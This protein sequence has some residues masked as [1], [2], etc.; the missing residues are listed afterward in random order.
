VASCPSGSREFWSLAKSVSSNFCNSSFPPLIHPDGSISIDPKSKADSFANLFSENSTLD[1]S[2]A[3]P[4]NYPAATATMTPIKFRSRKIRQILLNLVTNKSNG[5]D[6]IP[7]IVLKRCAPE[8]APTLSK[9]F[10]LSL[11]TGVYPSSWKSAII[12]PIPK[13]GDPSNPSNYRPI[14]VTSI[15]SKVMES[16]INS[17]LLSFL[18]SSSL[19]SD[20]Q[21]GFRQA[22]STGDLLSYVT[23]CWSSALESFGESRVVALDI[24]KAFDRV[25]HK[26]LI[27]KLPMFGIHPK[28]ISWIADFLSCRSIA[29]RIDGA[30]SNQLP[31]NS[32]V[33]QGSVISPTLFLLY[34]NDLLSITSNPIH[35]YADDSN[36]HNSSTYES[37]TASSNSLNT[38][39]ASSAASLNSDLDAIVNWGSTN[40]VSFNHSKTQS[41]L[42]SNKRNLTVPSISMSGSNLTQSNSISMLGIVVT[43]DLSWKSHIVSISKRAARKL[44]FLFRAKKFFTPSQLLI[45]YKSQVRP[46]MEYCCHIWGGAPASALAILDRL[47]SKAIRLIGDP[48]LS[49]NLQSLA[50]RRAVSSLCLFYRYYHGRC[51]TELTNSVP[52]PML[53]SRSTRLAESSH[54]FSVKL[55]TSRTAKHASSFFPRTTKLWNQLPSSVFPL[56]YNL[57][58]F[59]SRI[60]KLSL[61]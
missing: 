11:S 27:A 8:L 48:D 21:Y 32:G 18:E 19:L 14:A 42:I 6:G 26:G 60:N 41:L 23:N 37:Q 61:T 29:V 30:I 53:F 31:I 22:R 35:S 46:L 34:I 50:H 5:P 45:L 24:S 36:L 59:K 1:D 4:S 55:P 40:L 38:N 47:Q 58:A 57:Q 49:S 12:H 51:S 10:Q 17:Q 25:W 54:R 44:G 39:R 2:N 52:P 9:L 7:A 16:A 28:L 56:T 13:K 3:S 43:S 33:P 20:H 15:L